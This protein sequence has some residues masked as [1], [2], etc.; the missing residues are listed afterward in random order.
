MSNQT[1]I[2]SITDPKE[3]VEFIKQNRNKFDLSDISKLDAV[4]EHIENGGKFKHSDY[5]SIG[6]VRIF[7]DNYDIWIC[8]CYRP[9]NNNCIYK[10]EEAYNYAW[11]LMKDNHKLQPAEI[12]TY[13]TMNYPK[14]LLNVQSYSVGNELKYLLISSDGSNLYYEYNCEVEEQLTEQ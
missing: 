12:Y 14:D 13:L 2:K 9:D 5:D 7:D 8:T 4:I 10:G 3:M 11:N 1:V 6:F